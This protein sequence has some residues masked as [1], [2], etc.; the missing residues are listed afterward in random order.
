MNEFG[1]QYV[2]EQYSKHL[3][4]TNKRYYEL[5]EDWSGALYCGIKL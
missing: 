3:C 4:E 1:G 2:G 5:A